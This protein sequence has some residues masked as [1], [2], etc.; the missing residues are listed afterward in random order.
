LNCRHTPFRRR[1]GG[2]RGEKPRVGHRLCRHLTG[3]CG[4]RDPACPELASSEALAC[5]PPPQRPNL[6]GRP[7]AT[8]HRGGGGSH[9]SECSR[10]PCRCGRGSC[11]ADHRAPPPL[12]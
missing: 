12:R 3:G 4:W 10:S 11:T 2:H 8:A 6:C 7:A 9:R 5:R 1:P